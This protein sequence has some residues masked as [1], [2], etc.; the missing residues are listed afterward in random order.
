MN[1]NIPSATT[2]NSNKGLLTTIWLVPIVA[3]MIALWLVYDHYSK[4]GPTI[5]I[6]LPKNEGLQAGQSL[7]K[8][9][10]V[11]VGTVKRIELSDD[12]NSVIVYAQMKKS[13]QRYLNSSTK[14][15][16]VKPEVTFTGVSGLETILSGTY[17][18]MYAKRG[19]TD[20]KKRLFYG[21]DHPYSEATQGEYIMLKAPV[22]YNVIKGTPVYFKNM[23]AGRVEYMNISLDGKEIEFVLFVKREFVPYIHTD[24]KFWVMD[25]LSLELNDGRVGLKVAP[26]GYLVRSG[27]SFSSTGNDPT[28]RVPDD[29]KFSLFK[30]KFLAD[31]QKI[32]KNV[33]KE[34]RVSLA[35]PIAKLQINSPVKYRGFTVGKVKDISLR[36]SSKD[37]NMLSEITLGV[38][39]SVFADNNH[40]GKENF[41]NAIREGLHARISKQDPITGMLFVDLIYASNDLNVTYIDKSIIPSVPMSKTDLLA[42]V[43]SFVS[44]LNSL[45]LDQI[46][47]SLEDTLN[48]AKSATATL[49]ATLKDSKKPI[50]QILA[51]LKKSAQDLKKLT[52]NKN[53]LNIPKQT[54][55]SL[56][57]VEKILKKT[58]KLVS[59]YNNDL[60]KDR[61]NDTLKVIKQ[62]TQEMNR[63]IKLLNKKPNSIIFGG[64]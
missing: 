62:T 44:K 16:I 37:K 26:L 15:W 24:S 31:G 4:I 29:F 52:G 25:A 14:F 27:I 3:L 47:D 58:D 56:K 64:K 61:I 36:Y 35:D 12:G 42:Q 23:Q 19:S 55:R 30:N 53:T 22:A 43:E 6:L 5:K 10:N 51:S 48:S 28:K 21:L 54:L 9:K 49:D 45:P 38:D 39:V 13:A 18:D 33:I 40:S 2:K 46:I 20:D 63:F 50:A 7:I 17:I 57:Q 59:N 1:K 60:L 11:P 32:G 34:Y 8:Y 41:D